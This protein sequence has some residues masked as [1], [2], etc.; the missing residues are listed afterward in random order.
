MK[1]QKSDST[2]NKW[3]RAALRALKRKFGEDFSMPSPENLPNAEL[4]PE[5]QPITTRE[6]TKRAEL[7]ALGLAL[8]LYILASKSA[9]KKK[10]LSALR[11]HLGLR[12]DGHPVGLFVRLMIPPRIGGPICNSSKY[13]KYVAALRYC[14]RTGIKPDKI[15]KRGMPQGECVTVWADRHRAWDNERRALEAAAKGLKISRRR[16]PG[17]SQTE[18]LRKHHAKHKDRLLLEVEA[19]ASSPPRSVVIRSCT[20]PKLGKARDRNQRWERIKRAINAPLEVELSSPAEPQ[21]QSPT[22]GAEEEEL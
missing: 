1:P 10:Y 14:I 4:A 8:A 16:Q 12:N 18:T 13:S 3:C 19:T 9:S 20:L 2:P 21:Q 22:P 15:V 11:K 17:L 7:E 5:V 6:A